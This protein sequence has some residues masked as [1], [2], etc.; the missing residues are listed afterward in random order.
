VNT[1]QLPL[2]LRTP[3]DQHFDA[4]HGQPA[5]REAVRAAARGEA[6]DWLFLAG[7]AGSGKTHLLLAACAE[8]TAAGRRAAYLPLAAFAGRLPEALAAQEDVALL[9]LDGLDAI[10]GRREDEEALFH[11]HNRARASGSTVLYAARGNPAAI[12]L[13][14]PDLVT[15]LGQCVRFALEPLDDAGRRE[16]LRQRGARRGLELDDAVLD[17]LL[18]R[19][20]RDLG[21]LTKLLERIDRASLAAQRRVTIPFLRTLLQDG[22]A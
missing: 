21:S 4:F 11:C 2:S 5:V 14:L 8:A 19:V 18:R 7:P 10:A 3:P 15:R 17:Y 16:V 12:G 6:A 20:D 22:A 1:P 9:C 13:Q